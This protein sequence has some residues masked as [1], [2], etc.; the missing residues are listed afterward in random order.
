MSAV[1]F[2]CDGAAVPHDW[3]G[4]DVETVSLHTRGPRR[5]MNLLI[6]DLEH[7]FAGAWMSEPTTS[8]AS[9]ATSTPPTK[10]SREEAARIGDSSTGNG[11]CGWPSPSMRRTS[12]PRLRSPERLQECVGFLTQD[13]WRF[14]F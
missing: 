4:G 2:P 11:T 5:T 12:G 6:E 13:Q 10:R 14:A 7:A 3:R 1:I 9:R 8:S